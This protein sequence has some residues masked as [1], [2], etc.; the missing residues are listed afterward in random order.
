M[1]VEK[2]RSRRKG[3]TRGSHLGPS[4]RLIRM[5]GCGEL[6]C[7]KKLICELCMWYRCMYVLKLEPER[8]GGGGG[9]S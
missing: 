2:L 3:F 1:G 4:R 9:G 7:K 6:M 5:P 8:G